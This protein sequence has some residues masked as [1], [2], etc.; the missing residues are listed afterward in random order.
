MATVAHDLRNPLNT[1]AMSADLF[2]EDL[3]RGAVDT[4]RALSLLSR[5]E[6]ATLRMKALIEELV[7]ASHLE[8]GDLEV[9]PREELAATMLSEAAA[10]AAPALAEK[11][12]TIA[13][14]GLDQDARAMVD[15]SRTV[16]LLTK[17][18]AV[19]TKSTGEGGTI[20]LGVRAQADAVVFTARAF[21]SSGAPVAPPE[22]GRGG[23]ALVLARGFAAVQHGSLCI[24]PGD[25]FAVMVTLPIVT[26]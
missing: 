18:I 7:E 17:V 26:S 15:R 4:T 23:L 6:R 14:E 5:M 12:V 21:G 16:Q 13:L 10:A 1:F 24:A 2:R 9:R 8:G 25:A 20:V 3:E 11:H 19:A 22:E